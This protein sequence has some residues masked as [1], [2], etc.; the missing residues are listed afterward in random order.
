MPQPAKMLARRTV[1]QL[2]QFVLG[3]GP[4]MKSLIGYGLA[5]LIF[6]TAGTAVDPGIGPQEQLSQEQLSDDHAAL[7]LRSATPPP[8][9]AAPPL[10]ADKAI[11]DALAM[12][13]NRQKIL[14]SVFMDLIRTME[15]SG[16]ERNAATYV[17]VELAKNPNLDNIAGLTVAGSLR[18]YQETTNEK[19]DEAVAELVRYIERPDLWSSRVNERFGLLPPDVERLIGEKIN[20]SNQIAAE[21]LMEEALLRR[22]NPSLAAK[23]FVPSNKFPLSED[24]VLSGEPSGTEQRGQTQQVRVLPKASK[25]STSRRIVTAR[26]GP[27]RGNSP[28]GCCLRRAAT[29][30]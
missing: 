28:A 24:A 29:R 23:I 6:F 13:G 17:A 16:F 22:F 1:P 2:K 20:N 15:R 25:S 14:L 8:D 9:V 3:W 7:P 21:R 26:A 12:H 19:L 4:A 27:A 10:S 5:G 30:R 11:S 18:G